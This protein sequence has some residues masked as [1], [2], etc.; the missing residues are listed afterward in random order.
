MQWLFFEE[1]MNRFV[2]IAYTR[3]S[4]DLGQESLR[5]KGEDDKKRITA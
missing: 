5:I 4:V 2:G 3:S 1:A